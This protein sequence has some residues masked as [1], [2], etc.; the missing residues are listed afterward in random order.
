[1]YSLP[2]KCI[3][4]LNSEIRR[5]NT[6]IE[7]KCIAPECDRNMKLKEGRDTNT[8]LSVFKTFSLISHL[9]TLSRCDLIVWGRVN[10]SFQRHIEYQF[11][12]LFKLEFQVS[13]PNRFQKAKMKSNDLMLVLNIICD[14]D[15]S[16]QS[17]SMEN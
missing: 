6:S 2:P 5:F 13:V 7:L 8:Q 16:Q 11:R 3:A 10:Q 1:M 15:H 14:T 9:A 4:Q 17:T 12:R